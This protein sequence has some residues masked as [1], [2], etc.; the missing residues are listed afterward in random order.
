MVSH[1]NGGTYFILEEPLEVGGHY[2][3][4]AADVETELK[5]DGVISTIRT[6]ESMEDGRFEIY[7]G[8]TTGAQDHKEGS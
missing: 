7:R 8:T 6:P 1:K 5:D 2:E 3:Y 4:V